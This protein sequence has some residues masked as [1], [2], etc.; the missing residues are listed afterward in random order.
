M[1]DKEVH[2]GGELMSVREWLRTRTLGDWLVMGIFAL[3][4][5]TVALVAVNANRVGHNA[6]VEGQHNTE[7]IE[8]NRQL[9][10]EVTDLQV[11]LAAS[12]FANCERRN[13][14]LKAL[15]GVNLREI[16]RQQQAVDAGIYDQL[17]DNF[18]REQLQALL[19]Q[20][21]QELLDQNSG[22]LADESC[23]RY[24]RRLEDAT[25]TA[26]AAK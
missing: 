2:G 12:Q 10:G 23:A 24:E 7:R 11:K 3:L 25:T 19:D 22:I 6:E 9:L 16:E 20:N 15:R 21:K 5:V 14:I 4:L 1:A 18:S 17:F 26:G 8:Q 13:D